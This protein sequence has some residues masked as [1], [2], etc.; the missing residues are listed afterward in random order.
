MRKLSFLAAALV[1]LAVPAAASAQ[2]QKL[3][4]GARL[5]YAIAGGDAAKDSKMSDVLKGAIPLQLDV[6]Y[7]VTKEFNVGAFVSYG[8]GRIGGDIKDLCDTSGVDCSARDVRLG[9]QGTFAFEDLNPQFVPWIGFGFGYEWGSLKVTQGPNEGKISYRGFE[10]ADLQLGADFKASPQLK[11]GPF[12]SMSFGKYSNGKLE[13]FGAGVDQSG[14][15][16][17]QAV[18]NFIT[19]GVRG[20]FTL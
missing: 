6:G 13:G 3:T 8:F 17:E 10:L 7:N 9:V 1:A 4:L 14:K 20:Q 2:A 18:H 5:G 15:I 11:V 19:I 16:D 12:V